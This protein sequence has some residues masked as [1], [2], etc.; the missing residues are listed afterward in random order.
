M[1]KFN[2]ITVEDKGM[3]QYD[4]ARNYREKVAESIV[5]VRENVF[6]KKQDEMLL[7]QLASRRSSANTKK[8]SVARRPD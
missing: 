2:S 8:S 4:I 5:R 1:R 6:R 3:V 7:N